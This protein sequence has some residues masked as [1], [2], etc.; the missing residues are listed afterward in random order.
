MK[1]VRLLP[2]CF[3]FILATT[4][5][6]ALPAGRAATLPVASVRS[7]AALGPLV[8]IPQTWNNCGPASVAEV[9]AYWGIQRTQAQVQAV[10]RADGNAHGMAPYRVPAYMRSL[11]MRAVLGIAGS[12]RL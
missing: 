3:V 4:L 9:L 6:G 5:G 10:L 8:N 2:L 1:P 11:G 12:E 7:A